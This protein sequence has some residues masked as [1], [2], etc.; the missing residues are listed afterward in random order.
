MQKILKKI[1]LDLLKAESWFLI[2]TFA[3]MGIIMALQVFSRS[4]FGR[5]IVWSEE[6]TRHIFIWSTF[7]GMSFGIGRLT[8]I[9]LDYFIL[10]IPSKPR[11]IIAILMDVILL[12]S[13]FV[14]FRSSLVYVADQM[15]IIG[16][17]TGY[18]MGFVMMAMPFSCILSSVHLLHNIL[19]KVSPLNKERKA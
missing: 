17:T 12:W 19:S 9:N 13:L 1:H 3:V 14:I 8:H 6:L 7:I 4:L 11:Q 5:P 15:E 16:P 18:S 2:I 10:K